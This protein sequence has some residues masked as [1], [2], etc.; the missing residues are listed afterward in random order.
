[1]AEGRVASGDAAGLRRP[2]GRKREPTL[3]ANGLEIVAL[4]DVRGRSALVER[5][6][7]ENEPTKPLVQLLVRHV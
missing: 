5:D 4:E 2:G 1:H 6:S 7:L 3:H